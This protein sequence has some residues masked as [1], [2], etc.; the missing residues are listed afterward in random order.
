LISNFHRDVRVSKPDQSREQFRHLTP[1]PLV[2]TDAAVTAPRMAAVRRPDQGVDSPTSRR[3][4]PDGSLTAGHS[5]Q[6]ARFGTSRFGGA[7]KPAVMTR[8]RKSPVTPGGRTGSGDESFNSRLRSKLLIGEILCTRQVVFGEAFT[9]WPAADQKQA[10]E[11][12]LRGLANF[13]WRPR[14]VNGSSGLGSP[15]AK[16]MRRPEFLS[17]GDRAWAR[18]RHQCI[19]VQDH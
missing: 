9:V 7:R 13:V 4:P 17:A 5:A 1:L 10:S 8:S 15:R 6:I 19:Q 16:C 12:W 14:H 18:A 11:P 3:E 2:A